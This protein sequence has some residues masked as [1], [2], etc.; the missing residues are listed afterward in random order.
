MQVKFSFISLIYS[1]LPAEFER[2]SPEPGGSARPSSCLG[3]LATLA[4]TARPLAGRG[5]TS[6]FPVF[7]DSATHPVNLGV[8]CYRLVVGVDQDHLEIFIGGVLAH[9]VGVEDTETL[10]ST[11]NTFLQ[12]SESQRGP[13]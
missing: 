9:P 10:Q 11:A 3:K 6:Q 5:E 12:L 8:P 13:K 2:I 1:T 4:E 7:H